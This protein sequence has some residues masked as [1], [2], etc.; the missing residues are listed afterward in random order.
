[1]FT[2]S[3]REEIPSSRLTW[4]LPRFWVTFHCRVK[5]KFSICIEDFECQSVVNSKDRY[6]RCLH[7]AEEKDVTDKEDH[8][9]GWISTVV[10][11]FPFQGNAR[12]RFVVAI[13]ELLNFSQLRKS[14]IR[15]QL[16]DR[17]VKFWSCRLQYFQCASCQ[18]FV[19]IWKRHTNT[20]FEPLVFLKIPFNYWLWSVPVLLFFPLFW[21][22]ILSR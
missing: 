14:P 22:W 19:W 10:K 6:D 17:T 11:D 7:A 16:N 3:Q 1:M 2:R 15:R 4:E 12:C 8:S 9:F 20:K 5:I 13:S 18:I 21:Q